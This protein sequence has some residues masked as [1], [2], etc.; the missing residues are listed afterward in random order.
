[1]ASVSA[2]RLLRFCSFPYPGLPVSKPLLLLVDGHSLAFRAYYAF[3]KNRDGGLKTAQ[4]VPTSICFGFLRSL[5]DTIEALNPQG[6][7]IAF[8]T[9]APT[10]R[11]AADATYKGTRAETP[12]DF[13]PDIQNL[14]RL[15]QAF[16]FTVL[17]APGF[18]A[19][20]ILG[21]LSRQ[22]VQAGYAAKILSGD[23]DLFQLV[24]DDRR[25]LYLS[26]AYGRGSRTGQALEFDRAAVVEK[27]G[28]PP[29]QVIDFKAL[30]GDSSDNIPGVKG[31]GE[32]TAVKLLATYPTLDAIY[33]AIDADDPNLK[34]AT[35]NKL[36]ADREAAYH[37]QF[38][39]TIRQDI[40]IAVTLADCT[41]QGFV[42]E[43]VTPILA[44]LELYSFL[45]TVVRLQERLGGQP[46][47]IPAPDAPSATIAGHVA[48]GAPEP[49]PSSEDTW[50]YSPA[51]TAA[52]IANAPQAATIQ[53]RLI[54]T[55]EQLTELVT[56]LQDHT[57]PDHP[58]AWDTETTSLKPWD[59]KLVG[60]GCCW[61]EALDA[62]AYIPVGHRQGEQ[63]VLSEVLSALR[64]LLESDQYPKALQN[65]KYDRLIFQCQGITLRGV[66]FDTM[67]ASY[68]LDPENTHNLS[69]LS[70]RY[71]NLTAQSYQDLVP[72]GQTI[73]DCDLLSVAH[74]CG[75]DVF[76]TWQ[77]VQKLRSELLDRPDAAQIFYE[78]E[79]PLEP[80]LA[81]MEY[82]GICIDRAYLAELSQ[83]L[84]KQLDTIETQAYESAGCQFNLNS[85]KQL[86]ELLFVTLKLDKRKTRKT[87]TGY[88]TNA[89][90]LEKLQGDHPV[91]DA[92]VEH[93]T[94]SKL[95][96]TYVDALPELV[97]PQT[98][99]IHTDF[100]QAV[101]ATGRLS[102]SN[103][104]L[105]N[106][107]IR[108]QF[109]RQ[110]R[111]AFLPR[112][113]WQLITAD[114]SQ[115]EL[116]ILAHLSQEPVLVEAYQTG[117]DVHALT[118]QLL[119]EKEQLSEITA[120]ERRLGK[121]INFGVI[122][123]M[124]AQ[125]FAREAG[126]TAAEG[127]AFIERYN[128]RY[129][130]VFDYLQTTK[131]RAIAKGYVETIFGRR[132]Y[133]NFESSS[134]Q[135]LKDSDL[136]AINLSELKS[137]T[138]LDAQALRA[139]ANAPI[140][141]SSADIIKRAM[142]MLAEVLQNYRTKLLLQVHDELILEAPP[143]EVATIVPIVRSTMESAVTLSV[144]LLVEVHTG[145]TWM[146]AK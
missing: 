131:K 85:P 126:V 92:I 52:A 117:Q 2:S 70:L 111:K 33:A 144:P 124:G 3:A 101:T 32:K 141:G 47:A 123:G 41:L 136:E 76:T 116:R 7:A 81:A 130:K 142:A 140:Q 64:P 46:I 129:A 16:G 59:A 74:Y 38:L 120:E 90:V 132:R 122:Y 21:T 121:T 127:K 103:P 69:D 138:M 105:Q 26:N 51:E 128:Q 66:V 65:A 71:L 11:H 6:V 50:F 53:P 8:D 109:S 44:E 42:E 43:Q 55:I 94:L 83:Q 100:N 56:L 13:I 60:I 96:S 102:S 36:A 86:S 137:I 110:I 58:V 19:D 1:M 4:G 37:S 99:R 39:A 88:S 48:L 57:N 77:L 40:P 82:T 61:G 146:D 72:K 14:Q 15:L 27:L 134:L 22:A 24:D 25:V 119:F 98:D 49:H 67:L 75:M 54:T 34:G 113:G 17:T 23:R 84:A 20:D 68:T 30:C 108:T 35:R 87:K 91:V 125:R 115:I 97:Q 139:A 107:P 12:D 135:M 143:E 93:R 62:I 28:I 106:I 79:M 78:L 118:A 5:L 112:S 29:E 31:I 73:A 80:V 63:L 145:S 10:F 114:Y 9:A 45:N 95:K 104:N 133:F 89:A 18:E